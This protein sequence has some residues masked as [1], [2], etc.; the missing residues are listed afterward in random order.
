MLHGWMDWMIKGR[1]IIIDNGDNIIPMGSKAIHSIC[2][3]WCSG[4]IK[5]EY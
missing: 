5:L 3:K 2:R 4:C 1:V